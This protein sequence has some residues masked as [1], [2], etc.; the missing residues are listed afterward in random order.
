MAR[1]V[2]DRL[3][4]KVWDDIEEA[5]ALLQQCAILGFPLDELLDGDHDS[6]AFHYLELFLEFCHNVCHGLPRPGV[7]WPTRSRYLLHVE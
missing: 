2:Y 4:Q 5:Q 6:D 3:R 7:E 1:E